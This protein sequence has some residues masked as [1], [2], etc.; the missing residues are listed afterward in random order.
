MP[1]AHGNPSVVA[2]QTIAEPRHRPIPSLNTNNANSTR[3]PSAFDTTAST[4][5]SPTSTTS[6]GEGTKRPSQRV[7]SSSLAIAAQQ[8][9]NPNTAAAETF[10]ASNRAMRTDSQTP[11]TSTQRIARRREFES[12]SDAKTRHLKLFR[13]PPPYS[14]LQGAIR[15]VVAA[16]ESLTQDT[17]QKRRHRND[18]KARKEKA[19]IDL[20]GE[21]AMGIRKKMETSLMG[22]V[23]SRMNGDA[24][25]GDTERPLKRRRVSDQGTPSF[26]YGG[27]P[28]GTNKKPN[29]FRRRGEVP[30]LGPISDLSRPQEGVELDDDEIYDSIE[31]DDIDIRGG[32][33]VLTKN[34]SSADSRL[35]ITSS[36]P[37]DKRLKP[38]S[39]LP[40]PILTSEMQQEEWAKEAKALG[41]TVDKLKRIGFGWTSNKNRPTTCEN[42]DDKRDSGASTS[43]SNINR[44]RQQS[45]SGREDKRR[46]STGSSSSPSILSK[47]SKAKTGFDWS[48]WG[49]K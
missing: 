2:P 32:G 5:S 16:R 34:K 30:S 19:V 28:L 35:L 37:S 46:K 1:K 40:I 27:Q 42:A 10:Y 6:T 26:D 4:S 44:T 31:N 38:I 24:A 43:R 48:N 3:Q 23:A 11:K 12:L 41:I 22:M 17:E 18:V 15:K 47:N 13:E 8:Q 9:P 33:S 21:K 49:K 39:S 29:P 36:K 20:N 45:S 7:G 14:A 25:G